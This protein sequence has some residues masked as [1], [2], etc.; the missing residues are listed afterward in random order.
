MLATQYRLV[1]A[2]PPDPDSL[3]CDATSVVR[4]YQ[5]NIGIQLGDIGRFALAVVLEAGDEERFATPKTPDDRMYWANGLD[6]VA[7]I[8]ESLLLFKN[9]DEA[10]SF[11]RRVK[12]DSAVVYK[13]RLD[14]GGKDIWLDVARTCP[15]ARAK[16]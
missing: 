7:T 8:G 10:I 5:R 11:S 15:S 13:L 9:E 4:M 12:F 1:R 6:G 2:V 16:S 3:Y 14:E